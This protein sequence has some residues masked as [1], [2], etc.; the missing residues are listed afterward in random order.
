MNDFTHSKV[1]NFDFA[2]FCD[3]NVLK[4]YISVDDAHFMKVLN[5]TCEMY[6]NFP[7]FMLRKRFFLVSSIPDNFW[8]ISSRCILHNNIDIIDRQEGFVVLD[9]VGVLYELKSFYLP[10]GLYFLFFMAGGDVDFLQG[11]ELLIL[12]VL[13]LED[14]PILTPS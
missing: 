14:L 5:S 6:K 12:L 8:E 11:I 13:D 10:E 2:L 7:E 4:F 3:E 1:T 9:D